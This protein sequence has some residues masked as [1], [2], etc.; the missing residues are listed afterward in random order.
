MMMLR[1]LLMGCLSLGC[2]LAQRA[3]KAPVPAAKNPIQK[4]VAK[5]SVDARAFISNRSIFPIH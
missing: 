5:V 4:A 1:M 2:V 3:D